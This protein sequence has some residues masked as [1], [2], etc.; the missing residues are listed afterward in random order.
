MTKTVIEDSA[1]GQPAK[2]VKSLQAVEKVSYPVRRYFG[3]SS[4]E[5][6]PRTAEYE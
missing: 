3:V 5:R 6:S 4:G 1:L 2:R